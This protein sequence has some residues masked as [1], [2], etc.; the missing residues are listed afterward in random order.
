MKEN[1]Y[2]KGNYF[3]GHEISDY[4]KE[5]NRVDYET[6]AKAFEA[7]NAGKLM[8]VHPDYCD[9]TSWEVIN[10]TGYY[11]E[12]SDENEYTY[13]EAQDKI[14]ELQSEL[15]VLEELEEL[16]GEQEERQIEIEY[17]IEKLEEIKYREF[18]NY[19]IID[20][21]GAEIL[22][23]WTDEYVIYNE[24]L[25]LY[26]WGVDHC[27]TAWRMVLTDIKCNYKEEDEEN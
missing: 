6:L 20:S 23:D 13:E 18:Y 15:D 26:V 14:A 22:K 27:G 19:F 9:G 10:G 11:Y 8:E 7:I 12:D 21:N 4:G 25:D 17:D 16:T 1:K 24:E 2:V 3:Y 5:H